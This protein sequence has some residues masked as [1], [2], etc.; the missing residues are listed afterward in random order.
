LRELAERFKK[1]GM[2]LQWD[3]S[4][5]EWIDTHCTD[6]SCQRELERLIDERLSPAILAGFDSGNGSEETMIVRY[7]E[8]RIVVGVQ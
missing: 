4:I 3:E 2:Y 5:F 6:H 7:S 8:S 1:L